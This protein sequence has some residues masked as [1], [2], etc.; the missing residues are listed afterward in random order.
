MPGRSADAEDTSGGVSM[1][2]ANDVAS[3]I[4][5]RSGPWVDAMSL[6]KL[7][8]YV[9]AWHLAITDRPLFPEK[10]KAWRDGPV[11][12]QVWHARHDRATRRAAAQD[13]DGV[14]LD[15]LTSDLID[16]VIS[17]YGSMAAEELSALTHVEQPWQE[18]RGDL[19]ENAECREPINPES[20]ARFYRSHR[21][22]GGRTAADLAAVGVYVRSHKATEPVD[23]DAILESLGDE[24]GDPGED[25][26]GGANLH[27][28]QTYEADGI[29]Q[30][31][32]RTYAGA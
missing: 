19:P 20:M 31:A 17:A 8:Y 7:L 2:P 6:Q 30:V 28:G 32:H 26:W 13:V 18:A 22:L 15:E 11:V 23:V 25:Q 21:R 29:E 14:E 10:V 27:D 9:Q 16:L 24:Y 3:V 4:I 12:P 1:L 5:A